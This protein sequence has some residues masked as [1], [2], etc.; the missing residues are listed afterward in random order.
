MVHQ[1]FPIDIASMCFPIPKILVA[2]PANNKSPPQPVLV[3]RA[4]NRHQKKS[5]N[6]SNCSPY[7]LYSCGWMFLG[8]WGF[9]LLRLSAAK[10]MCSALWE[11]W[12]FEYDSVLG[13]NQVGSHT[14]GIARGYRL[15]QNRT[16]D[17]YSLPYHTRFSFRWENKKVRSTKPRTEKRKLLAATQVFN[18]QR[19]MPK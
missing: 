16:W 13:W 2:L 1:N 10:V 12:D 19:G 4:H 8:I 18:T 3:S 9:S 17:R 15:P 5:Y 11:A 14:T 7:L 6:L